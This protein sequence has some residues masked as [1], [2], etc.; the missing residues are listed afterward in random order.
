MTMIS[1]AT[2]QTK[3]TCVLANGKTAELTLD[4]CVAILNAMAR[5]H[6]LCVSCEAI[7]AGYSDIWTEECCAWKSSVGDEC[8]MLSADTASFAE[9]T[10]I[11]KKVAKK[12]SKK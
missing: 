12:V 10:P 9:A 3:L 5:R 7:P 2:T 11:V 6:M 4:D 1:K 8:V